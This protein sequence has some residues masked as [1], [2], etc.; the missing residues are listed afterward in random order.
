MLKLVRVPEIGRWE[1]GDS[2]RCES[3]SI[4]I[5]SKEDWPRLTSWGAAH[6]STM[7]PI[8][9]LVSTAAVGVEESGR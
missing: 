8:L 5:S 1:F 7:N 6:S 4:C 9:V 2:S 3:R